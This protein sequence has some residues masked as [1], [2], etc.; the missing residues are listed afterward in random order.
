M[1]VKERTYQ[2]F[3]QRFDRF[4]DKVNPHV[5][6]M[7]MIVSSLIAKDGFMMALDAL[8]TCFG[9]DNIVVYNQSFK[10]LACNKKYPT[11]LTNI[12][13]AQVKKLNQHDFVHEFD[14]YFSGRNRNVII[15]DIITEKGTFYIVVL[16]ND[17]VEEEQKNEIIDSSKIAFYTIFEHFQL[18]KQLKSYSD[19]DALTGVKSRFVYQKVIRNLVRFAQDVTFAVCDL[20]SL[21][22]IN[23]NYGHP[24]G[25]IYLK[26]AAKCMEKQFPKCVYKV[27]GDE[28]IIIAPGKID[29]DANMK[30][31]NANLNKVM[32]RSI[33]KS[34]EIFYINYGYHY[35]KTSETT[36]EEF[37]K[38]A[39]AKLS[40][41]KKKFYEA[42]GT[43][44]RRTR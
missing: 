31:A 20:L 18:I 38:N 39:D 34:T 14:K 1:T 2:N 44:E 15:Y 22:R 25:D 4:E 6:S 27:G 23:D 43:I 37:Y 9:S 28:F 29:I 24:I 26:H 30:I 40:E 13:K 32:K 42:H 33:K 7:K 16:D 10:M 11:P 21:K 19:V 5:V 35:G 17:I 41:D 12:V 8:N 36:G 3:M